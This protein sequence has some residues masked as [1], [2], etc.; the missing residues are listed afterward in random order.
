MYDSSNL[1][2][3]EE[4]K[5]PYKIKNDRIRFSAIKFDE[6]NVFCLKRVFV[7][8]TKKPLKVIKRLFFDCNNYEINSLLI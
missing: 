4:K 7:F 2:R 1:C 3:K 6:E 8:H 5:I